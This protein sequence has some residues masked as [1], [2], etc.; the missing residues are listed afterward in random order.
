MRAALEP[1]VETLLYEGYALYPYTPGAV[2]NA[3]PTPFGI[4]YPPIHARGSNAGFDHL[5]LEC[6]AEAPAGAAF[7]VEVRFLHATGTGNEATARSLAVDAFR[8]RASASAQ[9]RRARWGGDAG[10]PALDVALEVVGEPRGE[11]RWHVRVELRNE[12]AAPSAAAADRWSALPHAMLSVHVVLELG[13]GRFV[14][15]LETEG[16]GCRNVNTWPVL[17][18]PDDDVLVGA[19]IVLPDHPEL[20]PQSLGSLFDG[21]EIEE[22]LWLHLQTLSPDEL[23]AIAESDPTVRDAVDRA[24]T[25]AAPDVERLH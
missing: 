11:E 23:A 2:K 24:R 16:R 6:I 13:A 4:V 17:A 1:L 19:A 3:T 10:E 21:T 15:P 8:L 14:S 25:A 12:T 18:S 22:A 20:S 9:T 5:R 7:D